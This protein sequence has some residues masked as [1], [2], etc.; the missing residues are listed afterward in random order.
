[1]KN[2][3]YNMTG[4]TQSLQ[5]VDQNCQNGVVGRINAKNIK[6]SN[7]TATLI[8]EA[9]AAGYLTDADM[10]RAQVKLADVLSECI[11]I[12]TREESTSIMTETANNLLESVLFTIDAYLISLG[13]HE[14]AVAAV[15]NDTFVNLYYK[16]MKRLK[17]IVCET[18][19]LLVKIKRTRI[20]TPNKKYNDILDE[21]ASAFMKT[22]DIAAGA[23]QN[24]KFLYPLAI[25]VTRARGVYYV[26]TY[27]LHL[28]AEN[29]FCRE[30]DFLEISRLYKIICDS[31]RL[32]YA[33]A[34]FN[35]YS[36]VYL[37]S[38]FATYLT[39]DQGSLV[40]TY[41]DC[42]KVQKLLAG[43]SE[44][45]QTDII[46]TAAAKINRGNPDYNKKTLE[47]WLPRLINSIGRKTLKN[48]LTIYYNG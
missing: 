8:E 34:D 26:K 32:R 41:G 38:L 21:K 3:G 22:Y 27:L 2:D 23:H 45:E 33:N 31:K 48:H 28:H 39:K 25:P 20:N 13:G 1:M 24:P 35:I 16:G 30:Y 6:Y 14:A 36:S 43:F 7:Y 44:T 47:M 11:K 29:L 15:K 4:G 12:Y 37:N 46:K 9:R 5:T 17:L 42:D 10:E 18:L 40:L 19:G